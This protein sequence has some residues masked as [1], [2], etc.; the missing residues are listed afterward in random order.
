MTQLKQGIKLGTNVVE[1]KTK[2]VT[3]CSLTVSYTQL[4]LPTNRD[5]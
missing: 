2:K 4:T 3:D 5:V 1:G